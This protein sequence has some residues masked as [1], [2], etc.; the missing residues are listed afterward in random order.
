MTEIDTIPVF[1]SDAYD[2]LGSYL[3]ERVAADD[4]AD[5]VIEPSSADELPGRRI[6]LH[7]Q[8]LCR[9]VPDPSDPRPLPAV[10]NRWID[11]AGG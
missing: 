4:R 9:V 3:H 5:L 11:A 8:P 1:R 6:V 2:A 7:D 10:I